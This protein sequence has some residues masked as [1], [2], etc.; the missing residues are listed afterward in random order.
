MKKQKG[1]TLIALVITIIV[2]LI[3]AGITIASLTG[4]NGILRKAL[5]AKK[6]TDEKQ[7]EEED[8]LK[9]YE[10]LLG[11]DGNEKLPDNTENTEAGTIV[12]MPSSWYTNLPN[13]VST[14]DGSIVTS[15][16][17][18]ASV[19]GVSDGK[20]NTVP[21][22]L[23]FYYVGGTVD[24]GVV[25]SDSPNDKNKYKEQ[26]DVPAGIAYNS[27]GTVNKEN[28][29][30]QG[31]QFIW[32]PCTE[33]NYAKYNFGM[34]NS[35]GWDSLTNTAEF[36]QIEKYGGFYVARYEAGTSEITLTD[37]VKFEN[38]STGST[39]NGL[40]WQNGNFASNKVISGKITSKAGEIPYYHADYPTAVEMSKNMYNSDYVRSGLIT[41][42]MWDVM[43]KFIATDTSSDSDL[44]NTS[45]GNYNNNTSVTYIAGQGRYKTVNSSDGS[46][47]NAV[48]ADNSY[49]YGIRSTASSEGVKKKNL[50]DIAGN[51][52][53]WT[54]ESAYVT[55]DSNLIYNLRGGSFAD[56]YSN[57][58]VCYRGISYSSHSRTDRGFRPVLY[59]R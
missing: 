5:L 26:E 4:E 35:T 58:P 51:M 6:L 8:I 22:P 31:N 49:H 2:L 7:K 11:I 18:V 25:I 15:S 27:D 36:V 16:K 9:Q 40:G 19:Y 29:E 53:K 55:N 17:K 50:Y 13:K 43:L 34:Q 12:N 56:V 21:V 45:W 33:S 57:C 42:T 1:I 41:G 39:I 37:H 52:W 47:S 38:A 30:L 46:T 54:Q 23:E 20:A 14:E 24:S 10:K 32:I 44:K 59:I 28:S 3:L 48:V